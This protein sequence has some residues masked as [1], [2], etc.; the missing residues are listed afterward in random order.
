MR[1]VSDYRQVLAVEDKKLE[2]HIVNLKNLSSNRSDSTGDIQKYKIEV[3][4]SMS[5]K[6]L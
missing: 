4:L 3:R 5:L 2:R 6:L 1:L